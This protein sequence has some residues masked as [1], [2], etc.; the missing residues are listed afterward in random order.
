MCWVDHSGVGS[1]R[2]VFVIQG[3]DCNRRVLVMPGYRK[4]CSFADQ[5]EGR[6]AGVLALVRDMH[7]QKVFVDQV[8]WRSKVDHGNPMMGQAGGRAGNRR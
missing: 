3:L 6:R 5:G 1:N 2:C 8:L 7:F 4:R